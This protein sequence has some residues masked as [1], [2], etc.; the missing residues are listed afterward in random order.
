MTMLLD[1]VQAALAKEIALAAWA[2]DNAIR[3]DKVALFRRYVDGE[4]DANL[5]PEMRQL[6]RIGSDRAGSPFNSNHGDNIVQSV[7]DR[8]NVTSIEGENEEASKW[9]QEVLNWNRFDGLQL[10]VH[11]AA[12]R[13]ADSFVLVEF[14]NEAQ[15]PRLVHEAA[16]DGTCGMLVAHKRTDRSELMAAVK[17]WQE[18]KETLGDTVR[19]NIYYPDRIEKYVGTSGSSLQRWADDGDEWPIPWVDD[20]GDPLGVP[21][22]QFRNR[23]QGTSGYGKSELEDYIP[24]QDALN[25]TLYSMVMAAELS[26]FQIRWAKGFRPPPGLSPG[27]WLMISPD[28]MTKEDVADV[29]SLE[30]GQITQFIEQANFLIRQIE[31]V[32]RT[33]R[34]DMGTELSGEALKQMEVKLL[35]KVRRFQIKGGNAWEDVMMMAA[36]VASVYGT[37][38]LPPESKWWRAKWANPALRNDTETIT[39][40]KSIA[41]KVGQRQFLKLIAGVYEF[42]EEDIDRIIGEVASERGQRLTDAVNGFNQF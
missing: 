9:A 29:G 15:M 40:A 2:G 6:L 36:R 3:G 1:S 16:W 34:M 37:Q 4:H 31:A 27:M 30:Q 25:R 24:L 38:N 10:D 41:D 5:T 35:G 17:V 42:T 12:I 39:N 19:V 11:E 32:T 21:V 26:A 22:I 20:A 23:A 18:S 7:V 33:P 14:D 13:D 28:G 8:L